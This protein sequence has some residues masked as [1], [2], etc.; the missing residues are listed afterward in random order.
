M[1]GHEA[2]LPG[3]VSLSPRVL[4]QKG[5]GS[6]ESGPTLNEEDKV[7]D[8]VTEMLDCLPGLNSATSFQ[9]LPDCQ[10]RLRIT[11]PLA[12]QWCRRPP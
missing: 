7:E 2:A 11:T 12:K 3:E 6:Q 8:L 10:R 1:E 5:I 9:D 4:G